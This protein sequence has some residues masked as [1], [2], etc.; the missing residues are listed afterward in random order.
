MIISVKDNL[1]PSSRLIRNSIAEFLIFTAQE[2]GASIEARYEDE[3]IRL[4]QRL[5]AELFGTTRAS[6]AL[7]LRN[8]Y[9]SGELK[10]SA[11]CKDFLHV[12]QEGQRQI[13]RR[14][15]HYN[16][17]AIISMG[18]R[19][20]SVRTTRFRRWDASV[21]RDFAIRGWVIDRRHMENGAFLGK[22]YFERLLDEIREIRLSDRRFY[23]KVTDIYSTSVDYNKDAPTTQ[24]FF[25]TVQN[26]LHY[27][28]HGHTAA[29]LIASRARADPTW[30]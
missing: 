28:V 29:E 10:E 30:A 6:I 22:D 19:V 12:R 26:T 18:Y 9:V 11:T 20:N 4:T 17:D 21:L 27:A 23:Q 5:I 1:G 24:R 15:A 13:S 8:I 14:V 2:G 3:T 16:L 7:H 25:T